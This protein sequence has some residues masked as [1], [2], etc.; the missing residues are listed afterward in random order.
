MADMDTLSVHTQVIIYQV[1]VQ[2]TEFTR[3]LAKL[4]VLHLPD[5]LDYFHRPYICGETKARDDF[6]V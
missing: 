5:L 3:R 4:M 2:L 6:E 1:V